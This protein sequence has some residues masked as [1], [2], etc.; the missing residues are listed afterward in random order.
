MPKG[1]NNSH[2]VPA[3]DSPSSDFTRQNVVENGDPK[4]LLSSMR[5]FQQGRKSIFD[6]I[7]GEIQAPV[8]RRI[9]KM[10]VRGD[11]CE[12]ITQQVLVRIYM[13]ASKAKFK[14]ISHLWAWIYTITAREIYKHWKK[15]RPE[16]ISKEGLAFLHDQQTDPVNN[17]L[18][19]AVSDEAVKDVGEC[20]GRL[21]E[22]AR[23]HLLGPLAQE[24]SFRQAAAIHGLSLGQF[25]HRYEKAL[26]AVRK[27]MESK[28]H[29]IE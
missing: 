3:D 25:K 5:M 21:E 4:K 19:L 15:K 13:Y 10:G 23:L 24:I 11:D 9:Q 17:P 2:G 14:T 12:E 7:Y 29:E 20:I 8:C 18:Q 22:D 16:L 28:G 1:N 6:S 26:T 27:C